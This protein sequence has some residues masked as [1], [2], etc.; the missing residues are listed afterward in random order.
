MKRLL[1][2]TLLCLVA[3]AL[4]LSGCDVVKGLFGGKAQ[5]QA[6]QMGPGQPPVAAPPGGSPQSPDL[7]MASVNGKYYNLLMTLNVPQDQGATAIS[8]IGGTTPGPHTRDTTTSR[9]GTG[10]MSIPIGTS[11]E[12][13]G[14]R[15]GA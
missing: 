2:I 9:R 8:T 14:S 4:M 12:T 1:T 15:T 3:A 5:N 7:T 13:R 6:P 10:S 11:G